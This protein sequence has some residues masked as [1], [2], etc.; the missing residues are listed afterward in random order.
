MLEILFQTNGIF[1]FFRLQTR[2]NDFSASMANDAKSVA[3]GLLP[4]VEDV[5]GFCEARG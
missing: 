3:L 2:L 5:F 4:G 1:F